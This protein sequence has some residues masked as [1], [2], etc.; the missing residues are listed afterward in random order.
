MLSFGGNEYA[1]ARNRLGLI[2]V[3]A[4][5]FSGVSRRVIQKFEADD[6]VATISAQVGDCSGRMFDPSLLR[7]R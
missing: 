5:E 7:K 3:E 4:E 2:P 6:R 1:K